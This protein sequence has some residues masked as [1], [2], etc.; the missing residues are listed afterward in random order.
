MPNLKL[1]L[2]GEEYTKDQQILMWTK[3]HILLKCPECNASD[4]ML[5]GAIHG[6][7]C[8]LKCSYC[9]TVFWTSPLRVFGAYPISREQPKDLPSNKVLI[10]SNGP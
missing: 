4:S 10:L 5:P 3:I 1:S 8:N 2:S 7:A 9:H 6:P